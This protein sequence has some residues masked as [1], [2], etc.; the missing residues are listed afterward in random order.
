M[1]WRGRGYFRTIGPLMLVSMSVACGRTSLPEIRLATAVRDECPKP[2]GDNY[3]FPSGLLDPASREPG[4]KNAEIS[5]A[6]LSA[7]GLPSLSCGVGVQEAYRFVRLGERL[8]ALAISVARANNDWEVTTVEFVA[9]L[10]RRP[11]YAVAK[12]VVP[13]VPDSEVHPLIQ[14]IAAADFWMTSGGPGEEGEG[15][16]VVIEGRLDRS[17]R[18]VTRAA[19]EELNVRT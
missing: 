14:A 8:P 16:I 12:R 4:G 17:Y 9:P 2:T 10:P 6:Y 15:R 3:F 11:S 1:I 18:V 7:V 19:G 5:S 13:T